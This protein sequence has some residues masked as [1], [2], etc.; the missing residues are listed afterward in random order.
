[1]LLVGF[2]YIL[3]VGSDVNLT[4]SAFYYSATSVFIPVGV[5]SSGAPFFGLS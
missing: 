2:D 4:D 3:W 5:N 1:M